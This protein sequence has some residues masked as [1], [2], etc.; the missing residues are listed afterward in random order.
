M[1][2]P[3]LSN[4]GIAFDVDVFGLGLS[5]D[6]VERGFVFLLLQRTG[7][8]LMILEKCLVTS[9]ICGRSEISMDGIL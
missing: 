1:V 9:R 5:A 7:H 2:L 6:T 8:F 3:V 4:E